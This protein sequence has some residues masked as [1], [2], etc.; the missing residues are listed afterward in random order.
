[1]GTYRYNLLDVFTEQRFA[2]NQ[3]AVFVQARGLT[4]EQMQNIA[5]EMNLAETVF[6]LP[7]EEGGHARVRIFTPRAELGFAGHPLLGA[8]WLLGTHLVI[9]VL[10]LET[11]SGM[12]DVE[13][14]RSGDALFRAELV[15]PL[16]ARP[17]A[18]LLID[19]R[20]ELGVTP[21]AHL[22]LPT[23]YECGPIHCLCEVGSEAELGQLRSSS[24]LTAVPRGG[25][26]AFVRGTPLRARYFAPA[27]GVTEDAATGSA[28]MALAA[29]LSDQGLLP[30]DQE[31]EIVQGVELN[32]PSRIFVR[33][34]LRDGVRSV[35]L[36]G[37]AVL[38]GRGELIV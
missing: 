25:V 20:R 13:L 24:H 16:P 32:R 18:P 5:N 35:R 14:Y 17:E 7:A 22:L 28:A 3:L 34:E 15:R 37:S 36:G 12:V 8:A 38:A 9:P 27:L 33:T 1:M 31:F 10:R 11:A 4:G 2:G 23:L 30:D 21:H 19:V 26:L 6:V 29:F